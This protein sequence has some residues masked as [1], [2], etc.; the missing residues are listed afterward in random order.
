MAAHAWRI[1]GAAASLAL[2]IGA[3][4]STNGEAPSVETALREYLRAVSEADAELFCSRI[5]PQL[6]FFSDEQNCLDVQRNWV[7][8]SG[9]LAPRYRNQLLSDVTG[10]LLALDNTEVRG[11]EA[12]TVASISWTG[13]G[14]DGLVELGEAGLAVRLIRAEGEWR[15][16]SFSHVPGPPRD[17]PEAA[18]V[19]MA[20]RGYYEAVNER[21]P[22]QARAICDQT[23]LAASGMAG[24]GECRNRIGFQPA[25]APVRNEHRTGR[26]LGR[27]VDV[28]IEDDFAVATVETNSIDN[29]ALG[30]PA[31]GGRFLFAR[32]GGQWGY[33]YG[34]QHEAWALFEE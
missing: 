16:A 8:Q 22:A 24:L 12:V 31:T 2:I 30:H 34:Q 19:A 4:C 33:V 17:D 15:V 18:A 3:A 23:A 28:E 20:V 14:T 5:D 21:G 7:G 6:G 13:E 29:G 25:T 1:A 10:Q 9:A 27:I 11:D 26:V 32:E